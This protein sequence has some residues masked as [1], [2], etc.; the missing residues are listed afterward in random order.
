M[1]ICLSH[2]SADHMLE[3][4]ASIQRE[5]EPA[6]PAAPHQFGADPLEIEL[7]FKENYAADGDSIDVLVLDPSHMRHLPDVNVHVWQSPLPEGALLNVDEN[8]Y[9]VSPEFCLLLQA[10]ELHLI[11]LCQ[12]LGRYLAVRVPRVQEDGTEVFV[13]RAP[14]TNEESLRAFLRSVE[15]APGSVALREAMRWTCSGAASPQEVN[16]QLALTLPPAYGGFGLKKPIMNFKV[17]LS[18]E[19][20]KLYDCECIFID[21]CWPDIHEGLEYQGADHEKQLGAD[22]ARA[23]AADC[24][25]YRLW[26]VAKEQLS[27]AAQMDYLARR[28]ARRL[29]KSLKKSAWPTLEQ[30]QR[31][32]DILGGHVI[33]KKH[34]RA[35]WRTPKRG[36]WGKVPE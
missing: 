26:F 34:E 5:L 4:L 15:G 19:A 36:S 9:V 23:L 10:N 25:G 13:D 29:R 17:E 3:Y 8:L 11:N 28:L 14:L 1:S 12:M 32:L 24:E 35:R 6:S 31:L 22:Y 2:L 16:L 18:S 33:P 27:S 20:R 21:L 7:L 30:V